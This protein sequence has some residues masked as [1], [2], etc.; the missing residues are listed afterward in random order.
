MPDLKFEN[1]ENSK[2]FYFVLLLVMAV[3][4]L[5]LLCATIFQIR[6]T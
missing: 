5:V 2:I 1:F 4:I 3:T 6:N